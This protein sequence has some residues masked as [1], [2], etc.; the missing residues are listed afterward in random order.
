MPAFMLSCFKISILFQ[1]C[2]I[3]RKAIFNSVFEYY[4]LCSHT[5]KIEA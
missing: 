4:N 3:D 5:I 1:E 2:T